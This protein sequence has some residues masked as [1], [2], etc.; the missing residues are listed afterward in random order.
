M[1]LKLVGWGLAALMVGT[2]AGCGGGGGGGDG[3]IAAGGAAPAGGGA[4]VAV[5]PPAGPVVNAAS[6][7]SDQFAALAPTGAVTS[8]AI[9]SPPVVTF[10]VTNAAGNGV[11]GLGFTSK[12]ATALRPGLSNMAFSLAKL[13]PGT[14]GSPSKWVSYIVTSSPTTTAGETPS[15]PTTDNIGTL[16]DNGDGT[17]QYTF[18]RD[19]AKVKDLVAAASLTAPS[20]AAD[21]GDLTYDPSLLH[22]LVIQVGGNA[23][24]TGTN[25]ADGSNSGVTSVPMGSPVNLVFDWYP[26]TGEWVNPATDTD[27]DHRELVSISNCNECHGKLAFHG[28]NRVD[29]K[30]CVVC[31]TDQRKFGYANVASTSG[32]FPAL[33]ETATVST[34]TG[35]TSYRYTPDT[36]VADGEVVG[37]FPIMVHKI[38]QGQELVKENYNYANVAFNNK[39]YSMLGGGQKMCT[40]CHDNAKAVNAD[41]WKTKPSRKACG[42]CH[43]GIKWSDGTGMTLADKAAGG[44]TLSGHAGK[45]QSS[46]ATCALCH[47]AADIATYHQT[48]NV[49]THNPTVAAGLKNFTYEIK[50][51][52]VNST[53]NDV[54]VVF[55]ISADGTPV[56]FLP[57]ATPMANPLTGFTGSP[58]FLLAW[59]QTQDGITTPVDYNNLGVKQAQAISVSIA[60]LLDTAKAA[61]GSIAGPDAGYYTATLKGTGTKKFP[62]GAKMRAVA[63]QGYFTQVSPAAA[64]HTI[65]VV[66]EVTGD[67]ARRKVVDSDKCANCH[68]WFEGHGGNRVYQAQVCVM[69]HTPGLATSG[70]G[71]SDAALAA[72][73]FSAA[74]LKKFTDWGFDRTLVNAALKLPVTTNNFK[75][76]IHGIHAGR[77]RVTPFVDARDR[78]PS[79]I[80]LLDFRRM[81]FPGQLNNCQTCHVAGTYSSVPVGALSSTYESI[82]AA[83]AAGIAG[84]TATT[85]MA[86]TALSSVSTT[87]TVASPFAAACGSCHDSAAAL[88]HMATNNGLIQV[89][90]GTFQTSVTTPG[91]GEACAT[92][93]GIGK[94]EDA[95][96][97]HK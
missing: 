4:A 14:N 9:N 30:F 91:Q 5:A 54:T 41:N 43:D 75:D 8:V 87:D 50:S 31:H 56:T 72:Y 1:R 81:D 18:Y 46:D 39:G 70:R 20:V 16:V 97:V 74:D 68:E 92:C 59:T 84:G 57:A 52:A 3:T 21:L 25:T 35:I 53:S 49:T 2:L 29:T 64:R 62:V 47:G 83:Y 85:A 60:A 40:K 15:R 76:M 10:Q 45:A 48:E 82:D 79:A 71:I 17:Y 24:G 51:A 37:D 67:T 19:I 86:K 73:T 95:A 66:K 94:A 22:R 27:P 69:C 12:S 36:R 78:T 32:K 6:L 28:G 65:S 89:T 93:H 33:K 80:T 7:T 11:A 77:E 44:T 55:K 34:T 63:L 38:H 23:R 88:G 26:A 61:D 42:A 90:R 13:V 96:V 58:S